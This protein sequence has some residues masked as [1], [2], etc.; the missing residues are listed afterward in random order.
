VAREAS[1]GAALSPSRS[2]LGG[3]RM[4]RLAATC[5]S[6][7]SVLSG[8]LRRATDGQFHL[9]NRAHACDARHRAP[10]NTRVGRS[11]RCTR[12]TRG[13]NRMPPVEFYCGSLP[14]EREREREREL[15]WRHPTGRTRDSICAL[16]RY[17]AAPTRAI[18]RV[19]RDHEYRKRERSEF[20]F[21]TALFR[22]PLAAI[23]HGKYT[24]E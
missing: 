21:V 8:G 3:R 2:S 18:L 9:I 6:R 15:P 23:T 1:S 5:R 4:R 11:C 22:F 20:R 24:R 16:S 7:R 13:R 19:P 14:L 17:P 12:I 10:C